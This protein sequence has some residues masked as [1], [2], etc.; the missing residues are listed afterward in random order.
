MRYAYLDFRVKKPSFLKK[1]TYYDGLEKEGEV[2]YQECLGC[3]SILSAD[4]KFCSLEC[5]QGWKDLKNS[6]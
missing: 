2:M 5:R 6:P 3:G 1:K 4:K